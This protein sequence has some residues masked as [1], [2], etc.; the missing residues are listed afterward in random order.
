V[1][2]FAANR[3]TGLPLAEAVRQRMTAAPHRVTTT[4]GVVVIDTVT[5]A[6]GPVEVPYGDSRL[7]R[8]ESSYTVT[9]RR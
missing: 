2:V 7:R 9:L 1:D 5:T 4:T 3:S 8:W 6:Q